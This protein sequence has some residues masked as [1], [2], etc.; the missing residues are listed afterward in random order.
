MN[1]DSMAR[2]DPNDAVHSTAGAETLSAIRDR[3][4]ASKLLQ[5]L[6]LETAEKF[7]VAISP[8]G[9]F[10]RHSVP[11][12]PIVFRGVDRAD[13]GLVPSAFRPE[14]P[15]RELCPRIHFGD[16]EAI[17]SKQQIQ[18]ELDVLRRFFR[19][20]DSQGLPLPE[21]S[22]EVRQILNSTTT[23]AS[24]LDEVVSGE[25]LWPPS[26]LLSIMALSQ[27][28]GLPTRLLDWSRNPFK[29]AYFAARKPAQQEVVTGGA[30]LDS[31]IAVWA[32]STDMIEVFST[33]PK[34][35]VDGPKHCPVSVITC[36]G[37]TN[38]N[39][40]A[41]EGVFSLYQA[42]NVPNG[43]IVDRRPLE[44]QVCEDMNLREGHDI[45]MFRRFTLPCAE[46]SKLLWILASFG[47]SAAS[48][49]PDLRG[50]AMAV[51]EEN[52]WKRPRWDTR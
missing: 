33:I 50:A 17:A 40:R 38:V 43:P 35:K 19:F 6:D 8:F 22:Q 52:A 18:F 7:A 12:V 10:L 3:L 1:G 14:C 15:Y 49:F 13:Y 39:L 26:S 2:S 5:H 16:D 44:I 20:A 47:V 29:A 25:K 11:P 37:A 9:T 51:R 27:H 45:T 30:N 42:K 41:Q 23:Q 31:R 34:Y 48:L 32:M 4:L 46:A 24:Y 28:H 36:P 21:D